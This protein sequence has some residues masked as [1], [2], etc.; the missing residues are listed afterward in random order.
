M[1]A[2]L[3]KLA[4]LLGGDGLSELD[5]DIALSL[6]R[7]IY[8][9]V[10]FSGEA[11]GATAGAGAPAEGEPVAGAAARQGAEIPSESSSN[12]SAETSAPQAPSLFGD[13]E[14]VVRH[15]IEER[16]V[17]FSLYGEEEKPS[18]GEEPVPEEKPA[19]EVVPNEERATVEPP[20]PEEP[21]D[22]PAQDTS[23]EATVPS[24]PTPLREA[25]NTGDRF[26]IIRDLFDGDP[27]KYDEAMAQLEA[28][29]NLDDALIHID[30]N[31]RWNPASEG[32]RLL[33]GLLTSKLS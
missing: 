17:I 27:Q 23:R 13:E 8:Q 2:A 19:D 18:P 29:D 4:A 24:G 6:L 21:A 22:A 11:A 14:V 20:A 12:T 1:N 30:T 16:H 9:E 33:M 31:Y 7:D 10:K 15:V 26:I 3:E 32:A 25:V 28:F 5:R